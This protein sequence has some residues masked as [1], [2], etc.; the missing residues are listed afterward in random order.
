M[1]STVGGGGGWSD[2]DVV[3]SLLRGGG[4]LCVVEVEVV[5][6]ISRADP[7]F[8]SPQ[9]RDREKVCSLRR[10][11]VRSGATAAFV[12][13]IMRSGN[14]PRPPAADASSL[15]ASVATAF[16]LHPHSP[17]ADDI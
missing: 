17:P 1:D 7:H 5:E 15:S 12:S 10:R 6:Y 4:S 14:A 13:D 16:R 11:T 9:K 8:R 2:R 3:T